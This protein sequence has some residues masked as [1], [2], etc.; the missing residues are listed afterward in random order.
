LAE[1][2]SSFILC[3]NPQVPDAWPAVDLQFNPGFCTRPEQMLEC[4]QQ[5]DLYMRRTAAMRDISKWLLQRAAGEW[6]P[7]AACL[8]A[9]CWAFNVWIA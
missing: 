8:H 7:P 4:Q 1:L 9:V 5:P 6:V 2:D 3:C